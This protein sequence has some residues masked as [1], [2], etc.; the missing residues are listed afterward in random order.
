MMNIETSVNS[1]QPKTPPLD[2]LIIVG[3]S[4]G[5]D[6]SVA[7]LLLKEQGYRIAGLFMKNWEEDDTATQCTASED[8]E[9]AQR[10]CDLLQIKLHTVNF[11]AEYWDGVFKYFLAEYQALRT[12]NP[13][14]LCNREI[15]FKVFLEYSQHLGASY[16]ATGHYVSKDRNQVTASSDNIYNAGNTCLQ[17]LR[18]AKDQNKDQSYFLHALNQRQLQH[19]IFPLANLT[20]PEVRQIA[21]AAKL[22]NY[23]KK[24]STGICFIGEKK[25][26]QFL[27][28]YLPVQP[29][30]IVDLAGNRLG[31]HEGLMYYTIGQ[32]QGLQ[33]GGIKGAANA[34]WY[35]ADK[36]VA[37]NELVVVQGQSHPALFSSALIATELTWISG[38]ALVAENGRFNCMAKTRYRQP[39]QACTVELMAK[40]RAKVSFAS[41]QRAV[42]PGQFVVFY[43]DDICLGGGVII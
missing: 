19:A 30:V 40:N 32:R 43:Q 37:D 39:D 12:P 22:P 17:V 34:A 7:A 28:R 27:Q 20:K 36:K 13:D 31:E 4:G 42:T 35:V 41:P 33:I 21:A 3:M 29:G 5:V 23:Q 16:I 10:V 24:D 38:R 6:S 25:F 15:K 8:R 14:V 11:S 2:P 18:K 9:Y 26:K 1:T